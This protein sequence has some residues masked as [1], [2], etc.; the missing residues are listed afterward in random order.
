MSSMRSTIPIGVLV[1]C[2]A[3]LLAAKRPARLPHVDD[4]YPLPVDW[5]GLRVLHIGDSHVS[6]GLT[7][8]LGRYFRAA[9]ASYAAENW[10]GSR[11]RSWVASGKLRRMLQK[12]H[13][14]AVIVTLGTNAMRLGNLERYSSW[15]RALVKTVGPRRCYWLGPPPLLKDRFG[16]NEML[17]DATGDCRF[18]DTRT[19]GFKMRKDGKFHLTRK[20]GER[21]ADHVWDWINGGPTGAVPPA[22]SE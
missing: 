14:N 21:W 22:G 11:A 10:T 20:Q 4:V 12:Q 2:A 1:A 18:F 13:P 17:I 19:L 8:G 3:A 16:F 5:T 9:G 7:S 15:V 6:A